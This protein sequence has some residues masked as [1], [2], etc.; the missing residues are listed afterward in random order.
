MFL[1]L[2]KVSKIYVVDTKSHA[3]PLNY[4]FSNY[5]RKIIKLLG[6][7]FSVITI[8]MRF[9]EGFDNGSYR[10]SSVSIVSLTLVSRKYSLTNHFPIEYLLLKCIFT[11]WINIFL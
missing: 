6:K 2:L 5:F 1:T 9:P 10:K 11:H 7:L 4:F 8:E 3:K